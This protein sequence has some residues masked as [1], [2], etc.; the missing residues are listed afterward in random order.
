[1]G[2]HSEVCPG[3]EDELSVSECFARISHVE[4]LRLNVSHTP[5]RVEFE[6]IWSIST[7]TQPFTFHCT[8][9]LDY[10]TETSTSSI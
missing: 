8:A 7:L 3:S 2:M 4:F 1:M 5:G 6:D 9:S 10:T